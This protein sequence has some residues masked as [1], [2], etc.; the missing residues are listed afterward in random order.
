MASSDSEP[1]LG[2]APEIQD[3]G[4]QPPPAA[5]IVQPGEPN[6]QDAVKEVLKKARI[7]DGLAR[8]L[9]E[10]TKALDR[11]KVV[12]CFLAKNCE[13]EQYSRL[14]EA[15]C[16]QHN[17]RLMRVTDKAQLGEWAGLCRLGKDGKAKKIVNCNCVVVTDVGVETQ[18]LDLVMEY[19]K[20]KGF[21][22][23]M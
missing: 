21:N 23:D 20:S 6:I 18:S 4:D 7:H 22:T 19:F 2:P 1:E 10:A 5:A 3:G 15:L 12:M 14:I 13:V 8:G 16:K 9:H 17:I 11:G